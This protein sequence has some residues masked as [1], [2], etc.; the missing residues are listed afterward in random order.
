MHATP[1]KDTLEAQA[2]MARRVIEDALARGGLELL[3]E[4]LHPAF[5]EHQRGAPQGRDGVKKLFAGIRRGFP[6]IR[7]QIQHLDAAGDRVWVHF[8]ASGTHTGPMADLPPTGRSVEMEVFDLFR[9]QDGRIIEHW[10]V[11]DRLGM[12]EQLGTPARRDAA[13]A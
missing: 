5:V 9:F 4:F 2:T 10:G 1:T 12:L 7:I 3:D 6:D 8:L 11:P 13:D